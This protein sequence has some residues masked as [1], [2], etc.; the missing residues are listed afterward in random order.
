MADRF[1]RTS[2][3]LAALCEVENGEILHKFLDKNKMIDS[4]WRPK[5]IASKLAIPLLTKHEPKQIQEIV[6][7][8]LEFNVELQRI[9]FEKAELSNNPHQQLLRT[10]SRWLESEVDD[11]QKPQLLSKI[12]HKWERFDDL[13][14]LQ[15]HAFSSTEWNIFLQNKETDSRRD[16]WRDIAHSLGGKPVSYTHLTLPTILLV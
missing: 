11:V 16:F 5:R 12:P 14:V 9:E 3:G 10:V 8:S 15:Q 4:S 6:D 2:F 13:I 7:S 1:D